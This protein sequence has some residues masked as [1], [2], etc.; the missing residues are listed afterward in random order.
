MAF[1]KI[2]SNE[3]PSI[4]KAAVAL[5]NELYKNDPENFSAKKVMS[6]F[7]VRLKTKKPDI[8]S[9]KLI[10]L[11]ALVPK[12]IATEMIKA[13]SYLSPLIQTHMVD[14]A[15]ASQLL[16]D[17]DELSSYMGDFTSLEERIKKAA[18]AKREQE[19]KDNAPSD[20][21]QDTESAYY[22][23]PSL[24]N[25]DEK[26]GPS[27]GSG[28]STT[29]KENAETR[30]DVK[31]RA[32]G[33]F[34]RK[35]ILAGVPMNDAV[36]F[37]AAYKLLDAKGNL[38]GQ[39][40]LAVVHGKSIPEDARYDAVK[41][42]ARKLYDG[43][44]IVF[45]DLAG[46]I[47]RVDE[48]G[49]PTTDG[50]GY[51]PQTFLRSVSVRRNGDL[52][53]VTAGGKS[54][55]AGLAVNEKNAKRFGV[56]LEQLRE[57]R[58]AQARFIKIITNAFESATKKGI[59]SNLSI[60]LTPA[61]GTLGTKVNRTTKSI[62]EIVGLDEEEFYNTLAFN[63]PNNNFTFTQKTYDYPIE[64]GS[65]RIRDS[66]YAGIISEVLNNEELTAEEKKELLKNIVNTKD[67]TISEE[68][69]LQLSIYIPTSKRPNKNSPSRTK[70]QPATK[71][72]VES[73]IN[74]NYLNQPD[75]AASETI[76]IPKKEG[77]QIVSTDVN[78]GDYIKNNFNTYAS[79]LTDGTLFTPSPVIY[80]RPE[81]DTFLKYSNPTTSLSALSNT[82]ST[83]LEENVT[84]VRKEVKP[85]PESASPKT[86][87]SDIVV[88]F[89]VQKQVNVDDIF[90]KDDED[91]LNKVPG[92]SSKATLKQ[93]REAKEWFDNSPLSKH[94]SFNQLFN[95][96]NSDKVGEFNGH[97]ITLF[98]G[99][100]YTDL[101]HEGWHG[102]S[103]LYLTKGEKIKLYNEVIKLHG[104]MSYRDAEE[105]LAEDFRKY[106][107]SNG[108]KV[109]GKAPVRRSLFEKIL[110][111]LKALFSSTTT[112]A[113]YMQSVS[114]ERSNTIL[115]EAYAQLYT[116]TFENL[117]PSINNSLFNSLNKAV[118]NAELGVEVNAQDANGVSAAMD[119]IVSGVILKRG[120]PKEVLGD[121]NKLI[122]LYKH[123]QK[124][125]QI[126]LMVAINASKFVEAGEQFSALDSAEQDAWVKKN[127]KE[128]FEDVSEDQS[129]LLVEDIKSRVRS[130]LRADISAQDYQVLAQTL[131]HFGDPELLEKNDPS[132]MLGYHL[133]NSRFIEA[134]IQA[135]DLNDI[136]DLDI[137]DDANDYM[138][139]YDKSG[140]ELS[141]KD[142][143]DPSVLYAIRSMRVFSK[144]G[145]IIKDKYGFNK[146]ADF[147]VSYN[148]VGAALAEVY[149]YEEM[150]KA[151]QKEAARDASFNDLLLLLG[152]PSST[153]KRW[154]MQNAFWQTFNKAFVPL[155][156]VQADVQVVKDKR[157]KIVSSQYELKFKRAEGEVNN[158][159]RKIKTEFLKNNLKHSVRNNDG[160][161]VINISEVLKEFDKITATNIA[162]FILAMGIL[163]E[164]PSSISEYLREPMRVRSF[165]FMLNSL[166]KWDAAVDYD[167]NK[168]ETTKY[169]REKARSEFGVVYSGHSNL[170]IEL[171]SE[172]GKTIG[173]NGNN[174]RNNATG[175]TEYDTTLN[176]SLT[177]LIQKMNKLQHIDDMLDDPVL[178]VFHP[179]NNPEMEL[180]SIIR[181]LFYQENEEGPEGTRRRGVE[182]SIIN[183]NGVTKKI[184]TITPDSSSEYFE[185]QKNIKLDAYSKLNQDIV[186]LFMSGYVEMIRPSDKSTSVGVAVVKGD[187]RAK[188]YAVSPSDALKGQD[189]IK[190][191]AV[192]HVLRLLAG[193]LARMAAYRKAKAEGKL[194][195]YDAKGNLLQ[196]DTWQIFAENPMLNK[197]LKGS[198]EKLINER[199][200]NNTGISA[201]DFLESLNVNEIKEAVGK[202]IIEFT[203]Y[204]KNKIRDLLLDNRRNGGYNGI[205]LSNDLMMSAF[206]K[207]VDRQPATRALIESLV[208][209]TFIRNANLFAISN[210][211]VTS[212]RNADEVIKRNAITSTG[213]LFNYDYTAKKFLTAYGRPLTE[214]L[215]YPSRAWDGT[216][217]TAILK[218]VVVDQ[219]E[220]KSEWLEFAKAQYKKDGFTDAEI[221]NA[222]KPYTEMKEGDGQAYLTLDAYRLLSKASNEWSDVQEAIYQKIA[223]GEIINKPL[224]YFPVK[225]YQYNGPLVNSELRDNKT[226]AQAL[227]KYSLLP[228]VPQVIKDTALET[229]HNSMMESQID[230][231]TY[232]SGSKA[233]RVGQPVE[234]LTDVNTINRGVNLN[235][236]ADLSANINQIHVAYLKDQLRI[237]SKFKG[238]ATF[239]TQFR[240]LISDGI[241]EGGKPKNKRLAKEYQKFIKAVDN[242]VKSETDKL[243]A[244]VKDKKSLVSLVR[245]ELTRQDVADHNIE[246]ISINKNGELLINFDSLPDSAEIEKIL[247]AVVHKRLIKIK[248]KG[249]SL[250]QVSTAGFDKVGTDDNLRFY[251]P[252]KAAQAKIALQGDFEKLLAM[253]HPDGTM[254]NSLERLNALLKDESWVS[255]HRDFITITGVRIPVQGL[256]SMEVFE[257]AEFLPPV[258]GNII[259]VPSEL[260]AKSGGDFDVDKLTMYFPSIRLKENVEGKL[261]DVDEATLTQILKSFNVPRLTINERVYDVT[262][263]KRGS[264]GFINEV[265]KLSRN[266]LL[267]ADNYTKLIRPIGT[268]IIQ[269]PDTSKAYGMMEALN[270]TYGKT[271]KSEALTYTFN[272]AKHQANSIGKRAL[273]IS[274]KGNTYNTMFQNV[275][276]NLPDTF[277]YYKGKVYSLEEVERLDKDTRKSINATGVLVNKNAISLLSPKGFAGLKDQ[278]GM[279]FKSDVISQIINGHVDVGNDDFIFNISFDEV[280]TPYAL[281]LIDLGVDFD[282]VVY[283]LNNPMIKEFFQRYKVQ[284]SS[285]T[286]S[287]EGEDSFKEFSVFKD[288]ALEYYPGEVFQELGSADENQFRDDVYPGLSDAELESIIGTEA[289]LKEFKKWAM[290]NSWS[291]SNATLLRIFSLVRPYNSITTE[292]LRSQIATENKDGSFEKKKLDPV[293]NVD[294]FA[295]FMMMSFYFKP[296]KNIRLATDA[297]TKK[298]KDIVSSKRQTKLIENLLKSEVT[299]ALTKQ[300]LKGSVLQTFAEAKLVQERIFDGLFGLRTDPIFVDEVSI[301]IDQDLAYKD[302]KEIL[303]FTKSLTNRVQ[304]ALVARLVTKFRLKDS[305]YK[306]RKVV[307]VQGSQEE[308]VVFDIESKEYR[309]D[310]ELLATQ[311]LNIDKDLWA[312]IPKKYQHSFMAEFAYYRAYNP[313]LSFNEVALLA[314]EAL[315]IPSVL[316]NISHPS[317]LRRQLLTLLESEEVQ[318]ELEG[319]RLINDLIYYE[320]DG[321]A[322]IGISMNNKDKDSLEQYHDE[323]LKLQQSSNPEI[324][325]FFRKLPLKLL[326]LR[327]YTSARFDMMGIIS[328]RQISKVLNPAINSFKDLTPAQ[329]RFIVASEVDG[330][331]KRL[332]EIRKQ[333]GSLEQEDL[334]LAEGGNLEEGQVELSQG[335]TYQSVEYNIGTVYIT[336]EL[337]ANSKKI[338]HELRSAGINVE[339]PTGNNKVEQMKNGL[340]DSQVAITIAN[341]INYAGDV[342]R[343]AGD[344]GI[345]LN[346]SAA[347]KEYLIL[348]LNRGA[349][350]FSLILDKLN[351]VFA[352]NSA[353]KITINIQ[354]SVDYTDQQLKNL[355]SALSVFE[356]SRSVVKKVE[357]VPDNIP[358]D[359]EVDEQRKNCE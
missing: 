318:E 287:L 34:I 62:N 94:I 3:V 72:I 24:F 339:I 21:E 224:Q 5:A 25:V 32:S 295:E 223:A 241:Y 129:I 162:D 7:Y 78:V 330:N 274:A 20:D 332:A 114:E 240:K 112:I 146:L 237:N 350:E 275:A 313:S 155:Y 236:A 71:S 269:N 77:D 230:Y 55:T 98:A 11:T 106:A 42:S 81:L 6:E 19:K 93:I 333:D 74:N 61:R 148:K 326:A 18:A 110:G 88:S 182:L 221:E 192:P 235:L 208:L 57:A 243:R 329:K 159:E 288:M 152:K 97:A 158:I 272:L 28:L 113:D 343:V 164:I 186:F 264:N 84:K 30:K 356:G 312:S 351:S 142:L 48:N 175:E 191:K 232:E 261:S 251:E 336:Q 52:D 68:G 102:F 190:N 82:V 215:G 315:N 212:Y 29:S 92:I 195:V 56:T 2:Q 219:S 134:L 145:V 116:G 105:F 178:A 344:I 342:P 153:N 347:K 115:E 328:P 303:A 278:K 49:D 33:A 183:T 233:A 348:D 247:S 17:F 265:I 298:A 203:E 143:A 124:E 324:R 357:S 119:S 53:F 170:I 188:N 306:G 300:L 194:N 252:G 132:T 169:L 229:L 193:E 189:A 283:F 200:K 107:M 65:P 147:S 290:T 67:L 262:L 346:A 174:R 8:Q 263:D 216:L 163:P 100:N 294:A 50:T 4:Y 285:I 161:R 111:F 37:S 150:Y 276:A 127:F 196:G 38:I 291:I 226:N 296:I 173:L 44:I 258:A 27:V 16:A 254:I 176:N 123:V 141:V 353:Q 234:F 327:P 144:N 250:V 99:S 253:T 317:S 22:E 281:N 222:L 166:K 238:E 338:V 46:N 9:D 349:V 101:Y 197:Q 310:L 118:E 66:K 206:G 151:L 23:F 201:K 87:L 83:K 140:N 255:K 268:D 41:T 31:V 59:V 73:Y 305:S 96:V 108:T 211:G 282:T 165:N 95:I 40:T 36:T 91:V 277:I 79:F 307:Q 104:D 75:S 299:G 185:G 204:H 352:E 137:I 309:V 271:P 63:G 284:T 54:V 171:L 244:Q 280:V 1:C 184:E 358:T 297:D 205:L 69:V 202:G 160:T 231:V 260:V 58:N 311:D 80:F 130:V 60:P 126:Q 168:S 121:R 359:K 267:D 228:L 149:T 214:S 334:I 266:I 199:I 139:F 308:P 245:R 270:P 64:I 181:D 259:V 325:T 156:I 289:F 180:N 314:T 335:E 90:G 172:Y 131:S 301:S 249:E 13:G 187:K 39:Y 45:K 257:V 286:Q 304:A 322:L 10:T 157:N 179:D 220:R 331:G 136:L 302:E 70:P 14:F 128:F 26:T 85:A 341:K 320:N 117:T 109:N 218:E 345:K 217:R 321:K 279:H 323:L 35:L 207:I 43:G 316:G 225:K 135:E 337:N 167:I 256:N 12:F 210:G 273:G 47:V 15:M 319:Y 76:S 227:H 209:E 138:S 51:I 292:S 89:K 122:T 133:N 293:E 242:L 154:P 246:A 86:K 213:N 340:N 239:S 177:I 354:D 355:Q 248:I 125:L 198:L 103:Q 120:T